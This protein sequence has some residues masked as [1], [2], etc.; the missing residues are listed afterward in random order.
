[1]L[2]AA[3]VFG[4]RIPEKGDGSNLSNGHKLASRPVH[5]FKPPGAFGDKGDKPKTGMFG[6]LTLYFLAV[7]NFVSG[8]SVLDDPSAP[9]NNGGFVNPFSKASTEDI[10]VEEDDND[11]GCIDKKASSGR[12]LFDR[13]SGPV[14]D[15]KEG[16]FV[17][18]PK[19]GLGESSLFGKKVDDVKPSSLFGS[20]SGSTSTSPT[21]AAGSPA[22]TSSLFGTSVTSKPEVGFSFGGL[23]KPAGSTSVPSLT[24]SLLRPT[25]A[26]SRNNSDGNTTSAVSTPGATDTEASEPNDNAHNAKNDLDLSGPGPGEEDEDSKYQMKA[27]VY[28]STK[29]AFKK[30]GSGTLRV[31]KNREN[32][33]ARIV[34]RTD[35]GK[36]ILNVGLNKALNYAVVD[37]KKKNSIRVPEFL[38]GGTTRT[39]LVR[40]KL[41]ED[42]TR[43]ATVMNEEKL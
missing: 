4:F 1:V 13:I 15:K 33:K 22:A 38:P 25:S 9:V 28:E 23:N 6:I 40:V 24:S 36:V 2:P 26:L 37:D 17:A 11:N 19:I 35:I 41:A 8:G 3:P 12:S 31:L 14:S 29:E 7:V 20:V 32:G 42:A 34:V 39:W 30:T 21:P 27:L 43:L 10:V 18:S 16:G 5:G